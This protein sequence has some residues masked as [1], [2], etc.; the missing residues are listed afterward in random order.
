MPDSICNM[1]SLLE[2]DTAKEQGKIKYIDFKNLEIYQPS[3]GKD[4]IKGKNIEEISIET[5]S[6]T[7]VDGQVKDVILTKIDVQEITLKEYANF[8][9]SRI[10]DNLNKTKLITTQEDTKELSRILAETTGTAYY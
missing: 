8:A 3:E 10:K 7:C 9:E 6:E 4:N 1:H 5:S 2:K